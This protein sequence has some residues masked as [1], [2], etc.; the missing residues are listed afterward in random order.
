MQ[1]AHEPDRGQEEQMPCPAAAADPGTTR[2]GHRSRPPP[3][4]QRTVAARG[5][6][7]HPSLPAFILPGRDCARHHFCAIRRS[8]IARGAARVR[9]RAGPAYGS[10]ASRRAQGAGGRSMDDGTNWRCD[11][12]CRA[13]ARGCDR[14]R[15]APAIA[16]FARPV[17]HRHISRGCCRLLL[18]R[19]CSGIDRFAWHGVGG[20]PGYVDVRW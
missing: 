16:G 14:M 2:P 11:G 1:Q 15:Y 6:Q 19:H 13:G 10:L 8:P 9:P 20:I 12:T 4:P 3:P 7:I 17:A 5:A 18:D